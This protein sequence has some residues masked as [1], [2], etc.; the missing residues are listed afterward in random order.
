MASLGDLFVT[1]GA[2]IDGFESAFSTVD[3]KLKAVDAQANKVGAGFTA[4]GERMSS[5][6]TTL[7]ASV[8]A[9][10]TGLGLAVAVIAGKFEQTE[11]AFKN[12][13]GSA[14]AATEFL[15]ELKQF[16]ASTPFELPGLLE[17]AKKMLAFGFAASEVLPML[18]TIGD[19]VAGIGGGA[20][21]IDRV[22]L[23]LGQMQAKGKVSAQE[24]NQLAE[25]G[26]PAWKMLAEQIGVSIPQ[27]MKMAEQ[28]AISASVAIPAILAGM[29]AK[30]EGLMEEQSQTLLGMWSNL[31]DQINLTLM[32]IGKVLVPEFKEILQ[33]TLPLLESVKNLATAFAAM[34]TETQKTILGMVAV[35]AAIGP[36][37]IVVGQMAIAIGGLM[38]AKVALGGAMT[39]LATKVAPAA[40]GLGGM[41]TAVIAVATAINAFLAAAAHDLGEFLGGRLTAAL[42]LTR[43]MMEDVEAKAKTTGAAAQK[44]M[45]DM[46]WET[47]KAEEA[48]KKLSSEQSK[49]TEE[50]KKL[51]AEL[52]KEKDALKAAEEAKKA[53]KEEAEKL[54]KEQERLKEETAR[55]AQA[56]RDA[57][58][59]WRIITADAIAAGKRQDELKDSIVRLTTEI[60]NGQPPMDQMLA[61]LGTLKLNSVS[62]E[63]AIEDL[64]N[65]AVPGFS[66]MATG[67]VAVK[68]RSGDLNTAL[69]ALG[70]KSETEFRKVAAEAAAARDAV[71]GSGIATD[72]EKRTAVYKALEAQVAAARAAG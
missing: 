16:A 57:S 21:E 49:L 14:E 65:A 12:F 69:G 17:S 44:A 61:D 72:F 15:N 52:K 60:R 1:V 64:K 48:A 4:M 55:V 71:L 38:S 25:L 37:L 8:T 20:A 40:A 22:T 39:A 47:I 18:R 36:V 51:E 67:M 66:D 5:F 23:A 58:V 62:A 7:T 42:G 19:A 59:E 56:T 70:I 6:G 26:I 28:G 63:Q 32:D 46:A 9:P 10:I 41:A 45:G 34:D 68:D 54:K 33:S 24:M 13:L 50:Q 53:A 30:F 11:T 2:K 35:L 29:N 43:D 31:K 27:A 3:Q